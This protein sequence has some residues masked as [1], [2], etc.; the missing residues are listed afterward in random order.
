MGN[1]LLS[2]TQIVNLSTACEMQLAE[3]QKTEVE[4]ETVTETETITTIFHLV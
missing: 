3:I 4:T 1:R 2:L